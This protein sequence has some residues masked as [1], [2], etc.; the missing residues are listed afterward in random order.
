MSNLPDLTLPE[1]APRSMSQY[2]EHAFDTSSFPIYSL[3]KAPDSEMA[4]VASSI[5]A[6][7]ARS[8]S[9]ELNE[10]EEL[11]LVVDVAPRWDFSGSSMSEVVDYHATFPFEVPPADSKWCPL[12]FVVVVSLSWAT[13][14]VLLVG[15]DFRNE[16]AIPVSSCNALTGEELGGGLV[17]L[18]AGDE[19]EG[20][21]DTRDRAAI[22]KGA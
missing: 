19:N 21:V 9:F 1:E 16:G 7:A 22:G 12:A 13:D 15:F 2:G 14:G 11:G 3:V 20:F 8:I 10:L 17:S 4:E 6:A 5:N 18:R